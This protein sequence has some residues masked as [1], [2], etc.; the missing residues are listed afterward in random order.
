MKKLFLIYLSLLAIALLI[1][2]C[3]QEDLPE[4]ELPEELI[5]PE[6]ANL[7]GQASYLTL[8]CSDL[9]GG[10]INLDSGWNWLVWPCEDTNV[11]DAFGDLSSEIIVVYDFYSRP[12]TFY[13]PD[14]SVYFSSIPRLE[15]FG[16]ESSEMLKEGNK[17]RVRLNN[18]G[19]L[20]YSEQETIEDNACNAQCQSMYGTIGTCGGTVG[21]MQ[22]SAY[23]D[24]GE[25]CVCTPPS[26]T[27]DDDCAAYNQTHFVCT[28]N[29][30]VY[31]DCDYACTEFYGYGYGE[32]DLED[33]I[34]VGTSFCGHTF[35]QC[36]CEELT[37]ESIPCE[38][39]VGCYETISLNQTFCLG[40]RNLLY[41]GADDVGEQYPYVDFLDIETNDVYE[42]QI[43]DFTPV[44]FD[45]RL[46][47]T[48][49]TFTNAS[50]PGDDNF[51]IT[52]TSPCNN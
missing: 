8:E 27:I 39:Y 9:A 28:N 14:D 38:D 51:D 34:A 46:G 7:A 43:Y 17:Y 36:M 32:C 35:E 25:Q 16:Y 44:S 15:G 33:G 31:P 26:C 21:D 47:G 10:N 12:R 23:C 40:G 42:R 4:S 5:P 3:G 52:L 11:V 30:C 13:M 49:Y 24:S 18:G 6:D 45:L 2:G 19:T 48:T 1:V 22:G 41:L 50:Y 20:S 29:Q 37:I